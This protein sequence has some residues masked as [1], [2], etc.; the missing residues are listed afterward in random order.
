MP[1]EI[2]LVVNVSTRWPEVRRGDATVEEVVLGDW[3]LGARN[4]DPASVSVIIASYRKRVV[5]M[6]EVADPNEVDGYPEP[7]I[8]FAPGRRHR[9][10]EG[11]PSPYLWQRGELFPVVAMG[12]DEIPDELR[13]RSTDQRVDLAGFSLIVHEDGNATVLAPVEATVSVRTCLRDALKTSTTANLDLSKL[14]QDVGGYK[15]VV[16]D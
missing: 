14:L 10:F 8:R 16:M 4:I 12:I 6:F 15:L 1:G 2:A 5:A 13:P 9:Q 7:R 3:N 11:S